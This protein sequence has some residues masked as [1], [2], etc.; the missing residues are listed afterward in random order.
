MAHYALRAHHTAP[1]TTQVHTHSALHTIRSAQHRYPAQHSTAHSA[2][3]THN[4]TPHSAT[5]SYT[6]H[7]GGH[8]TKQLTSSASDAVLVGLAEASEGRDPRLEEVV[9]GQVAHPLLRDHDV[10]SECHDLLNEG[11]K[12]VSA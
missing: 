12:Q 5:H 8:T 11:R 4:H 1:H 7:K 2:L 6:A 3:H 9:L 10:R